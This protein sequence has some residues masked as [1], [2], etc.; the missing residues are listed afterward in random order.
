MGA[1]KYVR[2]QW[3]VCMRLIAA[4]GSDF[5]DVIDASN[6]KLKRFKTSFI[7]RLP[8]KATFYAKRSR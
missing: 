4:S 6:V 8:V 5:Y 7:R 3:S 1:E 2:E